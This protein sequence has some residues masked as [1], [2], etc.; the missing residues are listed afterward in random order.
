MAVISVHH[1]AITPQHIPRL[2]IIASVE[3]GL[4]SIRNQAEVVLARSK[5]TQIVRNG[6]L[7]QPN[8]SKHEMEALKE[9]RSD[10]S[11]KI[12]K[13]DKGNAAVVMDSQEYEYN[14]LSSLN[15]RDVYQILPDGDN[16]IVSIEKQ[17]N[18]L[19]WRFAEE[20]K[21]TGPTYYQLK[22]DKSVTPKIYG[23]PKLHKTEIPLRPIVSFIGALTYCLSKF[24]VDILSPLLTF[25]FSVKNSLELAKFVN[26]FQCN[27]DEC[28]V[29]FDVMSLFTSIPIPDVLQLVSDLLL[30]DNLLSERTKLSTQD[31]MEALKLCLHSTI[32]SFNSVLYR[33]TFG[34]PMGSCISPVIANIFM[35]SVE[36]AAIDSFQEPP[37]VCVRYV[38]DIFCVIK[39][40]VIDDFLHHI[41]GIS[42]TIKFTVETKE[43]CSLAFLNVK[44]S[45]NLDNT[46]WTN[47]IR[48][49]HTQIGI[50][51]LI[52]TI[53]FTKN[54]Q[55]PEACIIDLTLMLA[56]LMTEDCNAAS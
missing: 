55:S 37:R 32:F 51:N 6:K 43:N 14:L 49:L 48:N 53:P 11:I 28:L 46:L 5:I 56:T 8:L 35:E 22:C 20:N 7:P 4:R 25:E 24:L 15:N 44:V 3:K 47:T 13:A 19:L 40:S 17:V 39:V 50:Y 12:M 31:I 54:Q 1:F 21:I 36:R 52:L 10:T 45:R 2:D 9:L 38:D 16:S 42:L 34:A 29:P 33:Q 23:L 18:K 41:N 27:D 26:N 30:N